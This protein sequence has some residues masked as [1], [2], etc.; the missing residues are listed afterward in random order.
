MV[1]HIRPPYQGMGT[2]GQYMVGKYIADN[3][4]LKVMLSGEGSDE[5]FGGYARLLIVAGEE[6]PDGYEMYKVPDDYPRNVAAALAY[7]FVPSQRSVGG[8][9]SVHGGARAGGARTVHGP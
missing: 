8:R 4:D 2:F 6:L 3:T 1:P 5:L 7:D 9:R